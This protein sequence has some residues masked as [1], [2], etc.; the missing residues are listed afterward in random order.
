MVSKPV[1]TGTDGIK[2][3]SIN[4]TSVLNI[5][6]ANQASIMNLIIYRRATLLLV[7]SR[8]QL[9]IAILMDVKEA[10]TG[11]GPRVD[12]NVYNSVLAKGG[13]PGE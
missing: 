9:M 5:I 12:R 2:E 4:S 6:A 13:N 10:V 11:F 7:L 1:P 8:W 3:P